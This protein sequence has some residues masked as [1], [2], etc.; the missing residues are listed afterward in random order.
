MWGK[1]GENPENKN[2]LIRIYQ[3]I[4]RF[5][6]YPEPGYRPRTGRLRG[7][8]AASHTRHA[9]SKSR[10]PSAEDGFFVVLKPHAGV[11]PLYAPAAG[12]AFHLPF[13]SF[14]PSAYH[15]IRRT[16]TAKIAPSGPTAR[17][18]TAA[19]GENA[20]GADRPCARRDLEIRRK[21]TILHPNRRRP[22][23]FPI[24]ETEYK[25]KNGLPIGK[26][27]TL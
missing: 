17:F 3:Q 12:W 27:S 14:H 15:T 13:R 1:C 4:K 5:S 6:W 10:P 21:V 18:L 22:D 9:P 19:Q 24:F 23:A 11:S 26:Y 16:P 25:P 8:A 2:R 7:K 20:D